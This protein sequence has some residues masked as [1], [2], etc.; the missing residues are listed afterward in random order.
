[1]SSPKKPATIRRSIA[2]PA[3]VVEAARAAAPPDLKDN[4]NRLTIVALEEYAA[5]RCAEQFER[6]MAQMAGDAAIRDV[7]QGIEAEF[8]IAEAD[9]LAD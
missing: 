5:R 9:G 2:V 8:A 7:C 3:R 6:A 4:L 1:M